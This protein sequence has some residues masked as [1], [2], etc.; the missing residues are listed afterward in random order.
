MTD[1]L[2]R[3]K[4]KAL[5]NR[6]G[7]TV[8][9]FADAMGYGEKQSSYRTYE[10]TYKKPFLPIDFVEKAVPLLVD[11]GEPPIELREVWELAG[12]FP[13]EMGIREGIERAKRVEAATHPAQGT[14]VVN[15]YDISPQAG[16]GALI[17]ESAGGEEGHA[18]VA[19]W[20]MPRGFLENYLPDTSGLAV[21]RVIGNSMEPD[22]LPSERVLVDTR[23]RQLSHDGVYVLWNGH[24]VVIKQLQLVPNS[25]P[26]RVRIISVN[27][28]YPSDEVDLADIHIN[29]R[30]VGK[31]L[32]K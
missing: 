28:T 21:V 14:V 17:D 31:W 29:G 6:A 23:H 19:S 30:V 4:L 10:D 15:E 9:A 5:R 11:R 16:S 13:G 22:F 12:V 2:P 8:R 26:E 7:W 18:P 24:G 25:A 27:P 32:W 20:A 3:L 1:E